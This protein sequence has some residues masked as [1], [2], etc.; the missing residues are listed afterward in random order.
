MEIADVQSVC[1]FHNLNLYSFIVTGDALSKEHY[2]VYG[3]NN[4]NHNL[5]K[6]FIVL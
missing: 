4:T 3:L 5:D 2:D 6:F 1:D